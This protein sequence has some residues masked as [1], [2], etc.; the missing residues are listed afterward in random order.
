MGDR[1]FNQG[2]PSRE[3]R[4]QG[5]FWGRP[6]YIPQPFPKLV[7]IDGSTKGPIAIL[8]PGRHLWTVIGCGRG[9]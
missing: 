5:D 8:H 9:C 7:P 4:N 2:G 1:Q 3:K 6:H